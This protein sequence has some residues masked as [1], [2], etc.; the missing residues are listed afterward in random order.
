MGQKITNSSLSKQHQLQQQE[1]QHD[2][3][4]QSSSIRTFKFTRVH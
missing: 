1:Q 3:G 2:Y 4:K